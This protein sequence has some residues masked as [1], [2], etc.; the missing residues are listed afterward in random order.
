MN[1]ELGTLSRSDV[2]MLRMA[3]VFDELY[4]DAQKAVLIAFLDL[5]LALADRAHQAAS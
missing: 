3:L 1:V 2:Q 5:R 4:E